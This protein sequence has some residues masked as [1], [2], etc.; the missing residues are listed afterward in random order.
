MSETTNKV[1]M[2]G[3]AFTTAV[4]FALWMLTPP[5]IVDHFKTE[6][7]VVEKIVEKEVPVEV[8]KEVTKEVQ[9]PFEVIKEVTVIKEVPVE[10]IKEVPGV[11]PVT[12]KPKKKPHG[13]KVRMCPR[14][15]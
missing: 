10:I 2:C 4:F 11:C 6:Y 1:V 8:I 13:R 9:V 12:E 5:V 7:K 3:F 15:L 14:H